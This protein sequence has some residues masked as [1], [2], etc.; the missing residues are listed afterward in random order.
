MRHRFT[1]KFLTEDLLGN[2]EY[3]FD[4]VPASMAILDNVNTVDAIAVIFE[5]MSLVKQGILG[6]PTAPMLIIAA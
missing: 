2:R 4:Q 5:K 1:R 6:K 3:L